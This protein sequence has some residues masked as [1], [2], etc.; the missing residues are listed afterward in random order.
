MGRVT[1]CQQRKN[2][3]RVPWEVCA[4]HVQEEDPVCLECDSKGLL[5]CPTAREIEG[6]GNKDER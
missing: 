2:R 6:E 5:F 4:Y 3:P 1:V